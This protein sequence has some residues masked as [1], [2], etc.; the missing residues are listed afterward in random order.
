M[1]TQ[2]TAWH[3]NP[4]A[5]VKAAAE[6]NHTPGDYD[7]AIGVLADSTKWSAIDSTYLDDLLQEI[8]GA[9]NIVVQ[10]GDGG[11]TWRAAYDD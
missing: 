11:N 10:S 8:A 1:S 5:A 4:F 2:W 6:A 9:T 3:T 7:K